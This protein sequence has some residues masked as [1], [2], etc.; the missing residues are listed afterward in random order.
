MERKKFFAVYRGGKVPDEVIQLVGL[1]N[2]LLMGT[3]RVVRVS[4]RRPEIRINRD[5]RSGGVVGL[6]PLLGVSKIN[7]MALK[8]RP[9][10]EVVI[11]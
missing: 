6:Y 10:I 4:V 3:K 5:G 1:S 7:L 11:E 9:E 2:F 8:I